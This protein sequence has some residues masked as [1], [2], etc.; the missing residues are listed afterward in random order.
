MEISSD[1]VRL[2]NFISLKYSIENVRGKFIEPDFEGFQVISGPTMSSQY[3]LINGKETIRSSY[4]YHLLPLEE[5]E[6]MINSAILKTQEGEI[7]LEPVIIKVLP[8]PD[9]RIDNPG[10]ILMILKEIST[11]DT[12]TDSEKILRKKLKK[13][14]KHKI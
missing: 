9:G 13:G 8:N 10:S 6:F 3:S 1:S 7:S 4:S 11:I 12:L 5:G 2:G 14:K